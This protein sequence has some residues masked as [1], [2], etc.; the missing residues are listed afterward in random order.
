M[1]KRPQIPV[2]I[3]TVFVYFLPLD[4]QADLKMLILNETYHVSG[5]VQRGDYEDPM[6]GIVSPGGSYAYDDTTY[7]P[8]AA[9]AV[10]ISAPGYGSFASWGAATRYQ[11]EGDMLFHTEAWTTRI[12]PGGPALPYSY[13]YW[14]DASLEVEF[15]FTGS[16]DELSVSY[17][18]P[19]MGYS[20]GSATLSGGGDTWSL[21]PDFAWWNAP[22]PIPIQTGQT[23]TLSMS[24]CPM[25]EGGGQRTVVFSDVELVPLPGAALL[26]ALGLSIAGCC[27]RRK[28]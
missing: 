24:L 22:D 15:M 7:S 1:V 2:T 25:I 17:N 9:G 4:A 27:L 8:G 21:Y 26:G 5:Y 18:D 19:Y 13:G 6:T 14:A 10:S 12:G 16:S 23:Y 28:S 20:A 3:L 11:S